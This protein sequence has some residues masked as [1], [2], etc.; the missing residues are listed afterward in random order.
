MS[1][2]RIILSRIRAFTHARDS[3]RGQ[4]QEIASHLEE[5]TDE[6]LRQGL[7]LE[8]ARREAHVRFGSV[9]ATREEH[10]GA[11]IG[12]AASTVGT[13]LLSGLLY[14]LSPGD[15]IVLVGIPMLLISVALVA[16]AVPGWRATR[17]DPL[18]AVREE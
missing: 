7:S 1:K 12:L 18:R 6:H 4:E 16:C 9:D 11:G 2:L 13:P 5:A 3:D 8:E 14:G 15:P 10:I 17:I